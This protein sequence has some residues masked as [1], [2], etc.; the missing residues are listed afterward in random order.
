MKRTR[1]KD[2]QFILPKPEPAGKKIPYDI[3]L[4]HDIL[5]EP[6]IINVEAVNPAFATLKVVSYVQH[7]PN[8]NFEVWAIAKVEPEPINIIYRVYIC[9]GTPETENYRESG[10]YTAYG[11]NYLNAAL[12]LATHWNKCSSLNN[13][14]KEWKSAGKRDGNPKKHQYVTDELGHKLLLI[15]T[16]ERT[17]YQPNF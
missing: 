11:K 7:S 17:C 5:P 13:Y 16:G 4:K 2:G 8:L 10:S 14:G 1:I 9:S 3:T 12:E 6:L 15:T